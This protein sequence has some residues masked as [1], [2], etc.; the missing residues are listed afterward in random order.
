MSDLLYGFQRGG[1]LRT[2]LQGI[3]IAGYDHISCIVPDADAYAGTEYP[4]SG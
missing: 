2:I 4:L 1:L 3:A